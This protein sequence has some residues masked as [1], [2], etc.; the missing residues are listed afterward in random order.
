MVDEECRR[1]A[2]GGHVSHEGLRGLVVELEGEHLG[3]AT[4]VAGRAG[5]VQGVGTVVRLGT[6][7]Q[8]VGSTCQK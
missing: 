5:Q 6:V 3:E 2:G 7:L 8:H 4:V 1:R